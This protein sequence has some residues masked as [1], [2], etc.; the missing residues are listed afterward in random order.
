MYHCRGNHNQNLVQVSLTQTDNFVVE[1]LYRCSNVEVQRCYLPMWSSV[2]DRLTQY[3]HCKCNKN[4]RGYEVYLQFH[5]QWFLYLHWE[6]IN[7]NIPVNKEANRNPAIHTW[8]QAQLPLFWTTKSLQY[9]RYIRTYQLLPHWSFQ[10]CS[11]VGDYVT[12]QSVV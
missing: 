10:P 1:Q 8:C 2:M 6:S 7:H 12:Y 5:R 4:I 11:C 3:H 9:S